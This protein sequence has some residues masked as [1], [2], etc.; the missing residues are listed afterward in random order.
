MSLI[1]KALKN[2][3]NSGQDLSSL[4][5]TPEFDVLKANQ[6]RLSPKKKWAI[7]VTVLTTGSVL[8][9]AN[10]GQLQNIGIFSPVNALLSK[11]ESV[12]IVDSNVNVP[13]STNTESNEIS[14]SSQTATIVEPLVVADLTVPQATSVNEPL[15]KKEADVA[16]KV[17]APVLQA[18][19]DT[20]VVKQYPGE[21]AEQSVVE[22]VSVVLPVLKQETYIG[23]EATAPALQ[24]VVVNSAIKQNPNASAELSSSDTITVTAPPLKRETFITVKVPKPVLQTPVVTPVIKVKQNGSTKSHVPVVS[25]TLRAE[26]SRLKA[27]K[28]A[29]TTT[30][31]AYSGS[32][33][34]AQLSPRIVM[35]TKRPYEVDLYNTSK[36][37]DKVAHKQDSAEHIVLGIKQSIRSKD[38][39]T[40]EIKLH[41]LGDIAGTDSMVYKRLAAF[42]SLSKGDKEIAAV[43]YHDITEMAPNDL[44]AGYNLALLEIQLGR[45]ELAKKRILFLKETY[46]QIGAI[47]Q[48]AESLK[49]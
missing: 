28:S 10:A 27:E 37:V 21:I 38:F 11:S 49:D 29:E 23:T 32:D 19:I 24:E 7:G 6:S 8:M 42:Y 12:V 17:S 20:P 2:A 41:S 13:E 40:A 46:P 47:N 43:A 18:P 39:I 34:R 1:Y 15:L 14:K 25:D 9:W 3:K 44:E 30:K 5:P 22:K 26:S 48:L 4:E 35:H 31:L 33:I 45:M 36:G 16:P